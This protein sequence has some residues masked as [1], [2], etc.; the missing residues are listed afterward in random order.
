MK[1]TIKTTIDV[2]YCDIC[3]KEIRKE[4]D[5]SFVGMCCGDVI[6]ETSSKI[7]VCKSCANKIATVITRA[8]Y[9]TGMPERYST[10][11]EIAEGIEKLKKSICELTD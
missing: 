9:A 11:D 6:Y 3:G 1:K 7:D 5:I 8:L 2:A 10:D 4:G